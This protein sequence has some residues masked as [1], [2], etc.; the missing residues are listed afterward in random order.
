MRNGPSTN[1]ATFLGVLAILF[2][3]TVFAV[4][5]NLAREVGIFTSGAVAYIVGGMLGL[6]PLLLSS[7]RR[8]ELFSLSRSYVLVCGGLFVAYEMCLYFAIAMTADSRQVIEISVLNYLWPTMTLLFSIPILKARARPALA[9]GLCAAFAGAALALGKGKALD[10]GQFLQN[11]EANW[12]PYLLAL[13]C[14]I[15]WGLYSVMARRLAA[16]SKGNAVPF[17]ILISGV[18]F[19][20][21]SAGRDEPRN[22]SGRAIGEMAYMTLVTTLLAYV[23]W[24]IAMRRGR[25]VLV[26]SLSYFTPIFSVLISSFYLK[27]PAGASLWMGCLLVT[28]GA[29]ICH[30]SLKEPATGA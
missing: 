19:L 12:P 11:I 13:M 25:I 29:V 22:L 1:F 21:I 9:L 3:S 16:G 30:Y 20:L 24:D 17:F 26:A 4:A 23:F 15:A 7:S 28:V 8:R 5:G 18:L 10:A 14:A 6:V 2:W 27:T